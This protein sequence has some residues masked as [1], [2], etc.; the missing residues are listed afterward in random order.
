MDDKNRVVMF[1]SLWNYRF[2]LVLYGVLA[3]PK[4][5]IYLTLV[6]VSR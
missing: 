4:E 5:I 2:E 1:R 6:V 3:F